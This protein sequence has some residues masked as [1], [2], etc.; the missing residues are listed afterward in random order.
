[1][2]TRRLALLAA[3][4][5][6]CALPGLAHAQQTDVIRGR[7]TGPD[8]AAIEGVT[9]T[10]TSI[11]G[12]VSRTAKTD[13]RGRFTV[14]FPGGDG[15]YMVAF[16]S[17]GYAAKRFEVKRLADEDVLVADTRLT[18]IGTILDAVKVTAQR[19]KP[20]RNAVTPDVGGTEQSLNNPAVPADLLGDL[21]AMAASLPG[22]QSVPGQNGDA[23]GFSVLG[24][25]AD[26]NNTT[27][28]GMQFGGS[29][30]PRDAA[31]LASLVTSPY[32]VSRGGFSGAQFTLRTRSGSNFIT[33]GMSL[34]VDAPQM[35]WADRTSQSLGQKYSNLSL[36][37][38]L[39][40]PIKFDKA[41]YNMAYQIGRRASDLQTLLTTDATGLQ[42]AGV[43][44]DSVARFL[45]LLQHT[46]IPLTAG[47]VGNDRINGQGTVFGSLDFAPPS[48]STGQAL[49]LTF[50]GSWADQSPATG[51]A[52]ELPSHSGDRTSWRGG[53]QARHNAYVK[54]AVLSETSFGVSSSRIAATPYLLMPGGLVRVTSI[55]DDGSSGV[56]NLSFG[57]SQALNSTQTTNSENFLNQLSWVSVNNKHRI[58][59]T[60]EL[61]RDA[62]AQEQ[63][64]NLLGTFAF[65]SLS[66]FQAGLPT[67]FTRQLSPR[68]RDVSQLIGGLS[69]GDSYRRTPNL[70]FQYGVRLD[71]NHFLTEPALNT[72][73]E[74]IFGPRNDHTPS[75]AYLSPRLGFSWTYG[76]AAQIAGFEGAA[77]GPRAVVRGGIG[78]FQNVP[79]TAT[80]GSAMD[81]TGLPSA[82][83]QLTCVGPA[84][85]LPDWNAYASNQS[86][87][88]TRCADG[89]TGTVFA[90]AVPNVTLFA[91]DFSASRSIRSNLQW[92][93]P[94]LANRFAATVEGTYSLNLDQQGSV[95]LN[96]KPTTR[97]SLADE[98]G[99]PVFVQPTSI[100]PSTGANASQDARISPKYARVSEVRSDLRSQSR[101]ITFR[102]SPTT[103]SSSL[104]WSLSYVYSNVRE[105]FRGFN[106]TVGNP[107]AVEWGR[108]SF[109]S[110]HQ[111]VYNVGYNFF[112]FV[113]VNW[114]GSFRSGSPFTP[115][116]AGDVNGDGYLNDRAFVYS[117]T[118]ATDPAIASAMNNLLQNGSAAA[119]SCL[120]QQLGRLAARNSC[121]GP[122]ISNASMSISFNPVKVRMPQ[123]ATL[124]LQLSNPLGA[125][126]L[127]VHG[128]NGLRGWGQQSF[129]DQSLLYVR[130]F[131][132]ATN[133]YRY[134]VNQRFGSTNPAFNVFRTPVTLTAM[135]RF[136]IGP[137]RERQLLTQQLDR[138][139]TTDGAKIAEPFLK[140]IYG[141]G[142]IPN[143]MA[144]ILRQQDTLKL[145]SR[146]ADSIAVL[147][148]LYTIQNDSIW[149]PVAKY[150]AALPN[151]YD[152]GAA[153]DRYMQ[154]RRA[155]VDLL[156]KVGPVVKDILTP[157]QRRKLPTFVASYLEPR[158]LASIR[159]G[160]ASFTG[161]SF[162]GGPGFGG[163]DVTINSPV[164]GSTTTIT[165]SR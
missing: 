13:S 127:L 72:D 130:G 60:S 69:L 152:Q 44:S 105:Q 119:K 106:S 6:A 49:N 43:A 18:R 132:P 143:P 162:G 101:Q 2:I 99:R 113:R 109:D 31:V 120:S 58:K 94:V 98:S 61:R 117:P 150:L 126:D 161:S 55:F 90:S 155:S 141:T 76:T 148:R 33:R 129:P 100:V 102:L 104:N 73:L 88:P 27:L 112:D 158:Y 146:Q 139:R 95:D 135:L 116:V 125:A 77:R 83:Q 85:P 59:L 75:R 84:A 56:Q 87:I 51:L 30:L 136:D 80:L 145:T 25:G 124:S 111:L 4:F 7:V 37:G 71:G 53:L 133:R 89:T 45:S 22:V 86:A 62:S 164:G 149:S 81:N 9:I 82:V 28:N 47:G 121:Q 159:S 3:I 16:A 74:S 38:T 64:N 39:S 34:N 107:L 41:F 14:T 114:F 21:A 19:E 11:S 20:A 142:S 123:R 17:L 110:R 137:T 79:Q 52:T 118:T 91:K 12:N 160:T 8:S 66:D 153:Y 50:N 122:W 35:Q 138:G 131:D 10:V 54:N 36:G 128:S 40:G 147:N 115:M 15:D 68:V 156:M 96:F 23:D 165:I 65:N 70:Q 151:T 42:A 46:G 163:G 1:M 97:F 24:L 157:E 32:D 57:G 63:S 78:V 29:N 144:T 103:F 48:S 92:N 26:Q 67:S 5:A 154:G 108:S 140:A 134:E 93:G